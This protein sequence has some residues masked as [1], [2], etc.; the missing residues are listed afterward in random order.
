MLPNRCSLSVGSADLA[1]VASRPCTVALLKVHIGFS[2]LV[3]R[4]MMETP[5]TFYS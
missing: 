1:T 5:E 4:T 3:E 2:V